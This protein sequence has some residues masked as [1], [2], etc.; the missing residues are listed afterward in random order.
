MTIQ[1]TVKNS[2]LLSHKPNQALLFSA[3]VRFPDPY[4]IFVL[5]IYSSCYLGKP[6]YYEPLGTKNKSLQLCA[7][8]LNQLKP[9]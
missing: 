2:F 8:V 9:K 5:W 4:Q 1:R 3:T 6:N 7:V